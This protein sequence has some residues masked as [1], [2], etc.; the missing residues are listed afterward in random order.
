VNYKNLETS[1]QNILLTHQ[2]DCL[3]IGDNL[4]RS[5]D[6]HFYAHSIMITG[7]NV[8]NYHAGIEPYSYV[9]FEVYYF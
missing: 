7:K 3:H 2:S 1:K 8:L 4:L 6:H 5:S 9:V